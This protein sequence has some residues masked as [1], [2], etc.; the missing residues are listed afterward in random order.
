METFSA[1]LICEK[2][3][4]QK[5]KANHE[6]EHACLILQTY[7]YVTRWNVVNL[8]HQIEKIHVQA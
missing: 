6:H 1:F 4:A 5:T 3:F 8:S 7:L 2:A